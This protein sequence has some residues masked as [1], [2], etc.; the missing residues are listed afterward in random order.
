MTH[1]TFMTWL[2]FPVV[3]RQTSP[4]Y[5]RAWWRNRAPSSV[6]QPTSPPVVCAN[7]C[8][9]VTQRSHHMLLNLPPSV[10]NVIQNSLEKFSTLVSHIVINFYCFYSITLCHRFDCRYFQELNYL[11]KCT[12]FLYVSY[13][14]VCYNENSEN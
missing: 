13:T 8:R 1:Q 9:T 4:S 11:F 12:F 6:C 2:V 5:T 14:G 10:I 3:G 7:S